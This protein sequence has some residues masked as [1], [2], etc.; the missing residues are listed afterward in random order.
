MIVRLIL[1]VTIICV[2]VLMDRIKVKDRS[3]LS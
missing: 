3:E 2:A 1:G